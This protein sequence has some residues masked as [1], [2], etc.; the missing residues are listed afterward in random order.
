MLLNYSYLD[1]LIQRNAQSQVR[2][3]R[4]IKHIRKLDRLVTALTKQ[5]ESGLVGEWAHLVKNLCAFR[6]KELFDPL[7]VLFCNGPRYSKTK[8]LC[9]R[10]SYAIKHRVSPGDFDPCCAN[11]RKSFRASFNKLD[12]CSCFGTFQATSQVEISE[13]IFVHYSPVNLSAL[14]R[15]TPCHPRPF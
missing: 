10:R 12:A 4:A 1:V 9:H 14:I 2:A 8:R 15:L 11:I 13:G 7:Y 3:D 6:F 5:L